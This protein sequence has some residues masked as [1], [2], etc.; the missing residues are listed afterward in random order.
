MHFAARARGPAYGC[1]RFHSRIVINGHEFASSADLPPRYRR[2]LDDSLHALLP[3]DK[4]I[5]V[6][7]A[8]EYSYMTRGTAGLVTLLVAGCALAIF[9]WQLGCFR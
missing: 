1:R 6:A 5:G 4:A 8:Q 7:A 2:L 9:L 3:I